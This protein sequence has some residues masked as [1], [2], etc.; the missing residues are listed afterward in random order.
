MS[1]PP[2][3]MFWK[4]SLGEVRRR[5]GRA[6]LTLLGIVIGVAATVAIT[7]TVQ[8]T[9]NAHRHM[10]EALTGRAAL[11]VVA[12]GQGGFAPEV[13]DRLSDV[14]G[15]RAAVPVIQTPAALV[16]S[17][18]A[19]P[20]LALGIDPARDA[21]ARDYFLRQGRPLDG[22]DGVLLGAEFA[23]AQGL[24]LGQSARLLTPTGYAA[25]PV[26]G[27]LEPHGAAAFNG[28]AVA[29][30]PLATAQ[31]VF[32]LPG[33]I[34]SVQLVLDE[35]ANP[36]RVEAAVRDRLPAGLTVQA[37]ATRGEFGRES[38]A[39]TEQGLTA[40]SAS[41]LVAGG[42]VILNAFLMN[43]GER[44]R[45]LAVLRA[46]GA[47]RQQVTRL[48]VRE[49]LV[50]GVLGTLLGIPAGLALA[51]ALRGVLARLLTVTLPELHLS[52]APFVIAAVLGPGMALAAT[53][54][55]ARRA[56][57]RAPLEDL[58]QKQTAHGDDLRRWPGYLG[59][60]LL[61]VVLLLTL[62][63]VHNWMPPD[64]A[65]TLL[66]PSMAMY[67]AGCA[68][69][70]PLLLT[71]LT[72]LTGLL[73]KPLLGIEGGLALWQLGRHRT[74]T[75]LTVG[76]LIVAIVFA[77]GFGQSFLN[78][79]RHIHTWFD[80]I[81]Q[82]DY[83]IRAAWPDATVNI[84]TAAIPGALAQEVRSF[85][86]VQHVDQVNFVLARAAGRPVIVL[87][88]SFAPD[89][90][91]PL[92]LVDG[93]M[94]AVR[95]GLLE[96]DVVLGTA[97]A[98]RLDLGVGGQLT[99]ETRQGP[100]PLRVAG[101][102]AEY[103]GGGL[104]VYMEWQA[105]RH[106]FDLNGVHVLLIT[107][108]PG[109]EDAL[110]KELRAF[111]AERGLLFQDNAE[112]HRVFNRQIEGFLA[113]IW[114]LLSLVFVVASLGVVNTLTMNVLEQTRE[115]GIL[116]A[117]GLKR[118]QVAKLVAGQALALAVVSLLPGVL[119]GIGLAYLINLVTY[120]L[121]G[122][123]V[124]FHLDAATLAGCAAAAVAIAVA[125]G[126]LPARRAARLPVIE[127]LQYE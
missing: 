38:M 31:R 100:R 76:V 22:S 15:L 42:F 9:H 26:L 44:R 65:S 34:N 81:V 63:L 47:T 74:R 99:V 48:L 36:L 96:G 1:R 114:I 72:R 8:T 45:Q 83:Y 7:V 108:K 62:G 77:V 95:R 105:A 29:V 117:I 13:I 103:T 104:V 101:T 37:P 88:C 116:R 119:G 20:V 41:S 52:A 110:G 68:L 69:A 35:D 14:P 75:A 91:L 28:G 107:A 71:P 78:N 118:I 19:V 122:Q 53:L 16:G 24:A 66:A 27:L 43:L 127:A 124:P 109:A 3:P 67:L 46:L 54:V 93:E 82:T 30:M 17:S 89:R 51:L 125:A 87:A 94:A 126:L 49:A 112:V 85:P 50:Q 10:F 4:L 123:P 5:P 84:T 111:C 33:Q 98:H 97:L 120:P 90:P 121:A 113:L 25:L 12:E 61:A 21:A 23:D 80:Q 73:L 92:A 40:L 32:G 79:L 86:D 64:M 60:T 11:E 59:L 56:G 18:G 6:L 106:Y 2:L 58:L 115:L 70:A 57:R 55:P 39:S 102:A